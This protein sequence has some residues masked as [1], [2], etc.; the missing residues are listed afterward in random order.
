MVTLLLSMLPTGD[1]D[2][3]V[4]VDGGGDGGGDVADWRTAMMRLLQSASNAD[5]AARVNVVL[6]ASVSMTTASSPAVTS[7]PPLLP[8]TVN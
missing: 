4:I 7:P 1:D 6:L 5:F 3:D 2:E 8:T